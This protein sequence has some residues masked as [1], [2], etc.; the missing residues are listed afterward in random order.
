MT[1]RKHAQTTIL[2]ALQEAGAG[3][4]DATCLRYGISRATFFRWKRRYGAGAEATQRHIERLESA[5]A[6]CNR[7]NGRLARE[8]DALRSVVRDGW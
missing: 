5:L 8:L 7:Q 1:A 4:V 2:R 6:R 3:S